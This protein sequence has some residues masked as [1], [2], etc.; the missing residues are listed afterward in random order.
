MQTQLCNPATGR[1]VAPQQRPTAL[2]VVAPLRAAQPVR[3]GAAQVAQAV[4]LDFDAKAFQK[5]LVKFADSEEYIVRGGRDKFPKLKEAFA[6][7]KQVGVI[8]WGSQAPAQGQNLRESIQEAGLDIKV[9]IGLRPDSPSWGEA[10]ACGFTKAAGTLG[11]VFDVIAHSD[12]VVLLISDGA[13]VS[14]WVI[15]EQGRGFTLHAC[16]LL[17]AKRACGKSELRAPRGC[18]VRTAVPRPRRLLLHVCLGHHQGV[19]RCY[20]LRW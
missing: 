10:E 20:A 14:C 12:L 13:Q 7:I 6:G 9:C 17:N 2:P 18:D 16:R 3:R 8:G 1:A 4:H 15:M 11:E 19:W 5:E